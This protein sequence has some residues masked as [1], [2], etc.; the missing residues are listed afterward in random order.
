MSHFHRN[1]LLYDS[2]FVLR[3]KRAYCVLP[4]F[5]F[6]FK[7]EFHN[8]PVNF[9]FVLAGWASISYC[10][11]PLLGVSEKFAITLCILQW[12]QCHWNPE[13]IFSFSSDVNS[14]NNEFLEQ[15]YKLIIIY[16]LLR[17]LN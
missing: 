8:D 11:C 2:L 15:L 7:E 17:F 12:F 1:I 5:S 13:E 10:N 6:F 14:Q 16:T 9:Y 4:F 3:S